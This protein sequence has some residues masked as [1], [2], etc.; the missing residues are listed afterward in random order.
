MSVL[1]HQHVLRFWD[2]EKSWIKPPT[3]R[4]VPDFQRSRSCYLSSSPVWAKWNMFSP[5][6]FISACRA[7]AWQVWVYKGCDLLTK[8][9]KIKCYVLQADLE[10]Q[11]ISPVENQNRITQ[12]RKVEEKYA[13]CVCPS[14]IFS[15]V[16]ASLTGRFLTWVA[17]E[18]NTTLIF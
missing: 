11:L 17:L 2:Q 7:V 12:F 14:E 10:L 15:A 6:T 9:V 8:D 18:N 3:L 1:L 4:T 13:Y 5:A 16:F